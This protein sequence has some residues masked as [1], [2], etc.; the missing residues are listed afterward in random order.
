MYPLR[1]VRL[2]RNQP[3]GGNVVIVSTG[4]PDFRYRL[5]YKDRLG[6]PAWTD[7]PGTASIDDSGY[8][9]LIDNTASGA[10]Q[11]FYRVVLVE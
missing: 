7:L 5:Q 6:A 2:E 10:A 11:R 9:Q 1:V 3:D 8:L 4:Y